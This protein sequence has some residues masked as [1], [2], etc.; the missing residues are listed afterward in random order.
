M[1]RIYVALQ[2]EGTDCWRPVSATRVGDLYRID[3][4]QTYDQE[5]EQWQFPPGSVVRCEM[6]EVS[7]NSELVAVALAGD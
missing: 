5:D 7:G 2:N 1:A 6:K 3:A 4:N